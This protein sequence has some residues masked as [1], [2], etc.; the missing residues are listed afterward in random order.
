MTQQCANDKLKKWEMTGIVAVFL[1][2]G[3]FGGYA[4][5]EL[6]TRQHAIDEVNGIK[7]AYS[8]AAK[9][10]NDLLLMCMQQLPKAAASASS[11]AKSAAEAADTASH[12]A[13]E[14]NEDHDRK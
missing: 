13:D 9:A 1:I 14:L 6:S 10:K 2:A 3:L 12:L 7:E 8:E 5:G 4:L 11:A